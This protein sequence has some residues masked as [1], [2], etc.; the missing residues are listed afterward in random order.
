M[1]LSQTGLNLPNG[2]W[3]S[4]ERCWYS[5]LD[6]CASS[7]AALRLTFHPPFLPYGDPVWLASPLASDDENVWQSPLKPPWRFEE[8]YFDLDPIRAAMFLQIGP[9]SIMR[10]GADFY[11]H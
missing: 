3:L 1:L 11:R 8:L 5:R 4:R 10:W 2:R 6:V 7:L 9:D